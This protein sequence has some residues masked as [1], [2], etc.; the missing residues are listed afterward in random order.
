M[1]HITRQTEPAHSSKWHRTAA[2]TSGCGYCGRKMNANPLELLASADLRCLYRLHG[3]AADLP[4]PGGGGLNAEGRINPGPAGDEPVFQF[5][6]G[7]YFFLTVPVV[8]LI[9]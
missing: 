1:T 5:R 3:G 2:D 6:A 9:T 8:A 7:H 4:L